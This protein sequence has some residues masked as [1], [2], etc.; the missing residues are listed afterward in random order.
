MA[1]TRRGRDTLLSCAA[2]RNG[3]KD[4]CFSD[5]TENFDLKCDES[6]FD[7]VQMVPQVAAPGVTVGEMSEVTLQ[8]GGEAT[9]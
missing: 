7:L 2:C 1:S 6:V 3:L 4:V 9:V 8:A 5:L